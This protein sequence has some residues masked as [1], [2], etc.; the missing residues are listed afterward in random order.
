[1][2]MNFEKGADSPYYDILPSA[3]VKL[4]LLSYSASALYPKYMSASAFLRS[5]RPGSTLP[6]A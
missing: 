4:K 1:M 3:P 2:P 5:T 6:P